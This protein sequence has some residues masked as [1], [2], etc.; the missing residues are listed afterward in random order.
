MQPPL[1]A[2][3]VFLCYNSIVS[4]RKRAGVSEALSGSLFGATEARSPAHMPLAARM[5]PRSLDEFLGQEHLLAPGKSL[6]QAIEQDQIPSSIFWG[7]AGCGKSTLAHVIA[8]RTA[9]HFEPYSAVTSGLPEMRRVIASA[10]RRR[11]A[12]GQRTILFVDEIHRFNR[13]QQDAF[14]PHVENGTVILIGSTTENPFFSIISPLIS[15]CRLFT[16]EPLT[17]QHIE[18]LML[19]AL[20]DKERGLGAT[21]LTLDEDALHHLAEM[22]NGDARIAL[23][24]LE[25]AALLARSTGKQVAALAL[26]EEA[27]QKRALEYDKDQDSHYDTVSAFIKSMRGSDPDAALHYLARMLKAGEDPRFIARRLVV[28]AAEDVGLA[29]P[30]ALL[31]ATAAAHAVEFVGLPEARI[32]LAEATIYIATA[33]KSNSVITAIGGAM[34][35]VEKRGAPPVPPHL[36]DTAYPGAQRLGHGEGYL[37]PH[38]FP[39]GF[40][41]QQYM[42]E[43]AAGKAYYE[44]SE[45]GLEKE[46]ARRLQRWRGLRGGREKTPGEEQADE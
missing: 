42:P 40:V 32:P 6:R 19:R 22:S 37:Y 14:L 20:E 39:E 3:E 9:T 10:A 11:S 34:D 2:A 31:V 46:I 7:P 41:P 4:A 5:R 30:M 45:H 25:S 29:D 44:P 33:P 23:N 36:R 15:R 18:T 38:D 28:H 13:A 12:T 21:G 35:D 27:M 24:G 43:G 1:L 17:Q 26:V 16:F 8:A